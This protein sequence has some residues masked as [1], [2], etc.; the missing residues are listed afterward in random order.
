MIKSHV[1]L[2]LL[3]VLVLCNSPA[4]ASIPQA[5]L[6][7]SGAMMVATDEYVALEGNLVWVSFRAN[8]GDL[9]WVFAAALD[10]NGTPDYSN[11]LTLLFDKSSATGQLSGAF[12]VPPGLAGQSFVIVG[13]SINVDGDI[14]AEKAV[15]RIRPAPP[16]PD[17]YV[18]LATNDGG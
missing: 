4:V 10:K 14:Q 17:V 5:G 12:V 6:Q 1:S 15:M 16:P 18:M 8:P 11:L 2:A 7:I 13:A 9:I 3:G